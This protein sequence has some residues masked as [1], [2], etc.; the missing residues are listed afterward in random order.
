MKTLFD[1]KGDYL[2]CSVIDMIPNS[3]T[4]KNMLLRVWD[5]FAD[6]NSMVVEF[7]MATNVVV[8]TDDHTLRLKIKT[9]IDIDIIEKFNDLINNLYQYSIDCL[10]KYEIQ[11]FGEEDYGF[12]RKV[13]ELQPVL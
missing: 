8:I 10:E 2:V 4:Q 9:T 11:R 1:I 6:I 3:Y 5:Y 12:V 7:E 13:F